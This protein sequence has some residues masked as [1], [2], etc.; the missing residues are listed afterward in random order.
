[1]FCW[2]RE[3]AAEKAENNAE[4]RLLND[5]LEEQA[6]SDWE[7]NTPMRRLR[8]RSIPGSQPQWNFNQKNGKLERDG[9]G[10]I[11]WFRYQKHVLKPLL[12]P[13]AQAC[14][15]D[16]P[17]TVVMEDN[18]PAHFHRFNRRLYQTNQVSKLFW[19][20]NSP[21]LNPIEPV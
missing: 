6:R 1:L 17:A 4:L 20:G 11:D 5:Q 15:Q 10:G 14:L 2:P 13:F 18:A 3:S 8:L 9:N 12:F 16:R 19:P 21:D 7:L